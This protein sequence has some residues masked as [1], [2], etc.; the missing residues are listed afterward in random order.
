M[1]LLVAGGFVTQEKVNEAIQIAL[2]TPGTAEQ[3]EGGDAK[4]LDWIIA[5]E[6]F[7]ESVL[8]EDGQAYRVHWPD[9]DSWQTE[10]FTTPRYAIDAA[11]AAMTGGSNG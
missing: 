11:I 7:V 5:Q 2:N 10:L 4:R 8:T 3:Q 9:D 6:C 1:A